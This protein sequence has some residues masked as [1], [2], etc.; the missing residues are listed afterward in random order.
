MAS[1]APSAISTNPNPRDRPVSRSVITWARVTVPYWPNAVSKS[2]AVV[3]NGRLPTYRFLL[4]RHLLRGTR[5]PR[6][7]GPTGRTCGPEDANTAPDN[8]T[9]TDGTDPRVSGSL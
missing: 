7:L 5:P 9:L 1:S 4:M 3:L 6:T 2:A 8:P